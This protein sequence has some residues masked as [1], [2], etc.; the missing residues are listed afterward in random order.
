MSASIADLVTCLLVCSAVVSAIKVQSVSEAKEGILSRLKREASTAPAPNKRD[1][2]TF[3]NETFIFKTDCVLMEASDVR[4]WVKMP[5]AKDFE[6]DE[7]LENATFTL[8]GGQNCESSSNNATGTTDLTVTFG[9]FDH[10]SKITEASF[11]FEFTQDVYNWWISNITLDV[12]FK[13]A[14]KA[15]GFSGALETQDLGA[16]RGYAYL[17]QDQNSFMSPYEGESV[18][19]AGLLFGSLIVQPFINV[20]NGSRYGELEPCEYAFTIPLWMATVTGLIMSVILALGISMLASI[21]TM[22]RFDDPK[23]SKLLSVPSE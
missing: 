9:D 5:D 10:N 14:S 23:T 7:D 21:R 8:S 22:D 4:I 11:T 19:Q 3:G 1:S 6:L 13:N 12:K 18:Q 15:E 16:G 2:G 17:C 20:A